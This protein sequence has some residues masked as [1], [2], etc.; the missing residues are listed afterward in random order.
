[1]RG[2]RREGRGMR[3]WR[4]GRDEGMEEWREGMRDQGGKGGG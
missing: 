1:M 2:W 4:E 3:G